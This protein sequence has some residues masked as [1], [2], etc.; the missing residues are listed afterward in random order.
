M[1]CYFAELL[2]AR[3]PSPARH[4]VTPFLCCPS[5][6]DSLD[7]GR[8]VDPHAHSRGSVEATGGRRQAP[9][10]PSN[11]RTRGDGFRDEATETEAENRYFPK[12]KPKPNRK[13][14][15]PTIRFGLV[16]FSVFGEKCPSLFVRLIRSK[17]K[18]LCK[19]QFK[20]SS[21]LILLPFLLS[22]SSIASKKLVEGS[23]VR[24]F[25]LRP[26]YHQICSWF[27]SRLHSNYI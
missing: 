25:E 7:P 15:T 6:F 24:G 14:E 26:P 2:L 9:P 22:I 20:Q 4:D 11:K 18:I 12:L 13:I 5:S 10:S 3:G 23:T 21:C 1:R 16:R 8:Q 19:K 17:R 27:A